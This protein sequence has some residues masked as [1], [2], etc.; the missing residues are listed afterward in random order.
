MKKAIDKFH[1]CDIII[2]VRVTRTMNI[3]GLCKGSTADSDSVCEGSNPSP[4][5]TKVLKPQGFRTFSLL[6]VID[7]FRIVLCVFYAF[8]HTACLIKR[9]GT[10]RLLEWRV[11]VF[12]AYVWTVCLTFFNSDPE[13]RRRHHRSALPAFSFSYMVI[14]PQLWY[15]QSKATAIP[16]M[17]SFL[18][19]LWKRGLWPWIA[20]AF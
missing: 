13:R 10:P 9:L 16:N 19:I 18:W 14:C 20:N 2:F 17:R 11:A 5:A 8:F 1:L 3:A 12:S 6:S 4:A 15:S 7:F